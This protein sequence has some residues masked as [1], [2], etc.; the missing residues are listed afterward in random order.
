VADAVNTMRLHQRSGAKPERSRTQAPLEDLMDD[1]L[2]DVVVQDDDDRRR[3]VHD[4]LRA[5]KRRRR[6]DER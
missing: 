5:V 3:A 2:M 4:V 1:P 6:E